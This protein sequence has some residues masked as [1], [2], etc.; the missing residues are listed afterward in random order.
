MHTA[1]HYWNTCRPSIK[2]RLERAL[3][4]DS[5]NELV[6]HINAVAPKSI[7]TMMNDKD[8]V[9]HSRRKL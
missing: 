4:F 1:R 2:R 3:L 9:G 5:L 7:V 8:M 6:H